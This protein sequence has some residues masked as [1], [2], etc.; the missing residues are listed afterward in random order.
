M[1]RTLKGL[2]GDNRDGGGRL[3]GRAPDGPQRARTPRPWLRC[4]ARRRAGRAT[5]RAV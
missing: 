3:R 5:G 4:D 1:W 2:G